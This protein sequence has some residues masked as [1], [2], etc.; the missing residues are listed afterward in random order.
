MVA[1]DAVILFVTFGLFLI[2][3]LG[4]VF[5]IGRLTIHPG[6]L[7]FALWAFLAALKAGQ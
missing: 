1:W 5:N 2:S 6:W 7:A 4:G 3:A